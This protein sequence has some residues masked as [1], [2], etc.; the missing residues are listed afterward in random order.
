MRWRA[1]SFGW[2]V[3]QLLLVLVPAA[4]IGLAG[5]MYLW[6]VK[7]ALEESL[8]P[9]LRAYARRQAQLDVRVQRVRLYWSG[10]VL[11]ET[12]VRTLDGALLMHARAIEARLP[13]P[14]APFTIELYRPEVW[15]ARDRQGQWNIDPL[16]R[17]PRPPEP[18]P[19]TIRVLAQNGVLRYEDLFPKAPVR[20]TVAVD[21]LT[22]SQPSVSAY[23]Q[24]RGTSATLGTLRLDALT[25]GKRWLVEVNAQSVDGTALKPYLPRLP[26]D[27]RQAKGDV[28]VQLVYEPQQPLRVHGVARGV[29]RQFSFRNKPLP[30]RE[31]R[32][33]VT[34]TEAELSGE[35]RTPDGTTQAQLQLD[36][37]QSPIRFH[38]QVQASGDAATLWRILSAEK[39]LVNGKYTLRARVAG[40]LEDFR[41]VG[42]AT[43]ERMR[44][45]QGTLSRLRSPFVFAQGQLYLPALQAEYAGQ[46]LRG[47]LWLDTRPKTPQLRLFASAQRL[48]LQRI[49]ALQE[50]DL[51]GE[52]NIDLI[53][54][55]ALDDLRLDANL[56]ADAL[57]YNQQSLGGVRARVRYQRDTL[58]IPLAVLQGAVGAI[59]VSG[60]VAQPLANDPRFDLTVDADELDLNLLATLLGYAEGVPL[61]DETGKPLRVDGI[62]YFTAAIRGTRQSPQAV[63]EAVVFD[64]RLGDIGAEV[65]LANLN[66][67]ERELRI[68][69]LQILRRAAQLIASGV[70][71]LPERADQPPQFRLQGNLYELDLATVPDWL[72]RE[73]PIAGVAS[74]AFEAVG[75]PQQ[76]TVNAQLNADTLQFDRTLLRESRVAVVAR[77]QDGQA[78][79]EVPDA[80]AQVAGG[81]LQARGEW[82]SDGAFALEWQ[83]R[84]AALEAFAPYLPVEYRLTG[85]A[86]LTGA[87]TGTLQ[88]PT[89]TAQL[90]AE[91]VQLNGIPVGT[92]EAQAQYTPSEA[93]ALPADARASATPVVNGILNATFTLRTPDGVVRCPKF[94]C[95]LAQ[96]TVQLTAETEPL[97]VEWLRQVASAVPNLVPPVVAE[98]LETLQGRAQAQLRLEGALEQPMATLVLNADMLRWRAQPLGRLSLQAAWQG[99][100]EVADLADIPP[101]ERAL[102]TL[103]RWRTQQATLSELRWQAENAR[104]KARVRYTPDAL[105]ADVE[106]AQLPLR[107]ARLWD[108]SLPE[109]DGQLDLSLVGAGNPE[110]PEL[111]LSATLS[112]LKYGDYTVDQILLSQ[113]EW[114]EGVIQTDDALIRVGD[115]QA[116]LSGRVPFHWSPFG[117]PED[118][119]IQVQVRVREQPLTLLGQ[120][121]AIDTER[122]RGTLDA[123]LEITGTLSA[124]QPRGQLQV[125]GDA[126]ALPNLRTMLEDLAVAVEFD[127]ERARIVQAQA[128]S[129]EGGIVRL[130]GGILFTGEQPT[131]AL[132]LVADGF[133]A[134]EPKLP[135]LGTGARAV[136][137]GRASITGALR[138]PTVQGAFTVRRGF[139][140]LPAELAPRETRESLPIDPR[141]EV[142]VQLGDDSTFRNPNIDARLEGTLQIG[143]S[144]SEPTL[145]GEFNIRTGAL[146]L[147]TARLRIEPDSVARLT[148]PATNAAGETI[149]RVE[150]DARA[151]TSLVAPDF[152]GELTRYRIEVS[153]RGTLDDPER[154][155]LAARSEPPGLSEQ[156]I[157]TLLGRGQALTAL[158]RG[159]DPAQVFREQLGE[160]LTA[161]VLPELLAPLET[162]I[163]E[164]L[165]LE[166][167]TVDYTGLRPASLYLVKNLFDGFGITYRRGIGVADNEY[168]VRLFYRLPLRDQLLQRLRVGFGFD[169]TQTRFF[170][171]E[172]SVL[173]R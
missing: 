35:V 85:Q 84:N 135:V 103:R 61:Q 94:T 11:S 166:L 72:R 31:A 154:L 171:I 41:A 66:L 5:A 102:T 122:T 1:R 7:L 133:T 82:R 155:Q 163:A 18:T 33:Q 51:R 45:P 107:W 139:L 98:R 57:T 136:V 152:T 75:T 142:S 118:E 99:T 12:E 46:T 129:S 79:V 60:T 173:F 52:A 137:S 115:Y 110:S 8:P 120:F 68:A 63:M 157:L 40:T 149:A 64:G 144:L 74:G 14:N 96:N 169:H 77:F 49:P 38:G 21:E 147:P 134:V 9:A 168:Q 17:Q 105:D 101:L 140:Y 114:R 20:A 10:V 146:N 125:R 86:T 62:G 69:E 19:L 116:R 112:N 28:S 95:D 160:I 50:T 54:Y 127:G 83:L 89:L 29:A 88:T 65:A 167:F 138:Q 24:A 124:P 93:T 106:V 76:F 148:Y 151:T 73:L 36:W 97:P 2:R 81:Q 39:P 48:P 59:Q 90:V 44:T 153:V 119:P 67:V 23:L 15:I 132:Q 22:Y 34:F 165:D 113:V 164:A 26:I 30:W 70:V 141:F 80:Q 121:A 53:A 130:E 145:I 78:Q 71:Q 43:L 123:Q 56:L 126:L 4:I 108:P 37:S 42:E 170:F 104:L 131:A 13:T 159:A 32:F 117:V 128:R 161:R 16:L 87:A 162:G 172:G 156:T 109:L 25:D 55:G 6:Q 111:T 92:L 143:G 27:L 47:K 91:Q 3:A 150:L 58:E 100:A 158:A